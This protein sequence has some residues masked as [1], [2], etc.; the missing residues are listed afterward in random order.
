MSKRKATVDR[1]QK[2]KDRSNDNDVIDVV[3]AHLAGVGSAKASVAD[4]FKLFGGS[5]SK[6][7]F[8]TALT[9]ASESHSNSLVLD[10]NWVHLKTEGPGDKKKKKVSASKVEALDHTEG[11]EALPVGCVIKIFGTGVSTLFIALYSSPHSF[12]TLF[13]VVPQV[14]PSYTAPWRVKQQKTWTG[15][16]FCVKIAMSDSTSYII[17]NA[18]CVE[19]A[20]LLQIQKQDEVIFSLFHLCVLTESPLPTL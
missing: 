8:K 13:D 6:S 17:T 9:A 7:E 11:D 4:V 2:T 10:G 16:G 5:L 19:N 20:T 12:V 14:D 3:V 15:S 1:K 18:H